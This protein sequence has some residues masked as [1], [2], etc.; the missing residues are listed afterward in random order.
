[1]P[2]EHCTRWETG[3]RN[4]SRHHGP[5]AKRSAWMSATAPSETWGSW[6]IFRSGQAEL[7]GAQGPAP[8]HP[9]PGLKL[10]VASMGHCGLMERGQVALG[11]CSSSLGAEQAVSLQGSGGAPSPPRHWLPSQLLGV[12]QTLL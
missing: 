8:T 5:Q 2:P 9:G 1:M 4:A 6:V 7:R 11:Q 10:S 12:T 3:S